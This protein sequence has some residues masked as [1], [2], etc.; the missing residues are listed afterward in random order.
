MHSETVQTPIK[1]ASSPQLLASD[2]AV[3]FDGVRAIDGVDLDLRAGEIVGLIGP[4]GAGKTTMLNVLSGFQEPIRGEIQLNQVDVTA[5]SPAD[6]ARVGIARA[7][8]DVRLFSR[9]TVRENIEVAA[10]AI[11]KS[12][13]EAEELADDLLERFGLTEKGDAPASSLPFGDERRLGVARAMATLPTFLFLDEPSAGLNEAESDELLA[14]LQDLRRQFGWCLLIV[15]HD[16]RLMM[17]L[18]DRMYVLDHGKLIAE[19]T[20]AEIRANPRVI[21]AYLGSEGGGDA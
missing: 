14:T 10:L 21:E 6:L 18:C 3:Y 15:E 20:P 1:D 16:M 7:F 9:L 11:G 4:N 13:S 17:R 12:R 8:Q 2:I 5:K 19:G